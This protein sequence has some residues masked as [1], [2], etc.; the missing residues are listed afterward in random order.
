VH[1]VICGRDTSRIADAAA[2]IGHGCI[3]LVAD[4]SDA[5]GGAAFIA[6]AAEAVGQLDI[7]VANAG[8]PPAGN[9]EST[10]VDAYDAALDLNLLSVVGMAKASIP[11]MQTRGWGRFVAITSLSVRQPMPALIL[12]NT[13]RAGVTGF[14][15]TVA[16]EVAK[17]GVTVNTVQPGLHATDRVA[18]LYGAG[19]ADAAAGVPAGRLGSPGDFGSIVAFVCSAQASYLTGAH[20]N[21]DGGA[22]GGLQ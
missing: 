22:Y 21:V 8:G 20:I 14:L 11:T 6:A 19:A 15:K 12:S 5:A 13:A 18:Q 1:V 7:V 2:E 9:F 16:R 10:P 4:V 3:G 17:D